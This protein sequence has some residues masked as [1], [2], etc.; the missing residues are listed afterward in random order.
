MHPKFLAAFLILIP[1]WVFKHFF[2]KFSIAI[3]L[4]SSISFILTVYFS[5]IVVSFFIKMHLFSAFSLST[6]FCWAILR[7]IALHIWSSVACPLQ[8]L[9]HIQQNWWV[10]FLQVIWLHPLFFSIELLHLGHF[11]VLDTIQ[12]MSNAE[13][14]VFKETKSLHENTIGWGTLKH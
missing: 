13:V 9:K 5:K 12:H 10:Q 7:A 3:F 8:L 6:S 2:S 4:V 11:L 1:T 14:E